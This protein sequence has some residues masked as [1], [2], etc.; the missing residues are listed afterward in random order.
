MW[1]KAKRSIEEA[2]GA[3][4]RTEAAAAKRQRRAGAKRST[5]AAAAAAAPESLYPSSLDSTRYSFYVLYWYKSAHTDAEG[6]ARCYLPQKTLAAATRTPL[7][8]ANMS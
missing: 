8:H 2:A 4:R 7:W 3:K 6:A 1:H 5:E